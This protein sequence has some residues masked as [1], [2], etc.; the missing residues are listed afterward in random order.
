MTTIEFRSLSKSR[1]AMQ[2]YEAHNRK[3]G[4]SYYAFLCECE[5]CKVAPWEV[6]TYSTVLGQ[7]CEFHFISLTEAKK[8]LYN[9]LF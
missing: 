3:S 8:F 9:C 1:K 4:M 6:H 7:H 5:D 2:F